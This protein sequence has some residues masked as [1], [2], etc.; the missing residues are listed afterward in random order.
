MI[1]S[2]CP[3]EVTHARS[4]ICKTWGAQS[5]TFALRTMQQ[6]MVLCRE[7][8][9]ETLTSFQIPL[10]YLKLRAAEWI[11]NLKSVK[12]RCEKLLK[13][14]IEQD[15]KRARDMQEAQ[16]VVERDAASKIK[17]SKAT[18]DSAASPPTAS[19]V[20]SA[21][22]KLTSLR[23][24]M[25]RKQSTEER[26]K[27]VIEHMQSHNRIV[28]QYSAA[29]DLLT[30]LFQQIPPNAYKNK[31]ISLTFKKSTDKKKSAL[32]MMPTNLHLCWWR[33]WVPEELPIHDDDFEM[34]SNMLTSNG[35]RPG[36]PGM[37]SGR[38]SS[39]T[40]LLSK[41]DFKRQSMMVPS[42]L[43]PPRSP[44]PA[45]EGESKVGGG[46]EGGEGEEEGGEGGGGGE[47]SDEEEEEEQQ[48]GDTGASMDFQKSFYADGKGEN[49]TIYDC[50]TFGAPAAHVLG[51]KKGGLRALLNKRTKLLAGDDEENED[52]LMAEKRVQWFY[53]DE[54]K[55]EQGPMETKDM[56]HWYAKA[57]LNGDLPTR[58]ST[59]GPNEWIPLSTRFPNFD[60]AFPDDYGMEALESIRAA[61]FIAAGQD[62]S[63]RGKDELRQD[64][65]SLTLKIEQRRDLIVCQSL[66]ALVLSFGAR[67]EVLG[68]RSSKFL[69]QL[70]H[71]G[72]LFQVES[73]V[74][75]HGDEQGML[76]DFI[77]AM[78][79]L[80][81][82]AFRLQQ[83]GG[84]KDAVKQDLW[85][86][87]ENLT[88]IRGRMAAT[89]ESSDKY[90]KLAEAS[91]IL[92]GQ[93]RE[94]MQVA[95]ESWYYC[96]DNMEVR[97]PFPASHMQSWYPDYLDDNIKI[98][99]EGEGTELWM[100]IGERFAHC[101]PFPEPSI[102]AVRVGQGL[103]EISME[104][105]EDEKC[106]VTIKVPDHLWAKLPETLKAGQLI[107][108]FPVLIQQGI[109]EFQTIANLTGSR[110]KL[111]NV[112]NSN[113]VK[114]Y[115][116]YMEKVEAKAHEIGLD[117]EEIKIAQRLFHDLET[118]V[119]KENPRRKNVEIIQ[120]AQ[121]ATRAL[122]GGRG[123]CCKSAKDRTSMS[124]TLEEAQ[125]LYHNE[126]ET[127]IEEVD[128]AAARLSVEDRTILANANILREYGV[129][130]LL[131]FFLSSF[132]FFPSSD[133]CLVFV[134]AP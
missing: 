133:S 1:L 81:N 128:R 88:Q 60:E 2:K 129:S 83:L 107:N 32:R 28:S 53:L 121:R 117:S 124:H 12:E 84:V 115:K 111:Q 63:N 89:T 13:I 120:C 47:E 31:C 30:P 55:T 15:E 87:R 20:A 4:T 9:H 27:W 105:G 59:D 125:L 119:S 22:K 96:D 35:S 3:Y 62:K 14:F 68:N 114:V 5:Q 40:P 71:V 97:G 78:K 48:K 66:S 73:L 56:R 132:T 42:M 52:L 54:E 134:V 10:L 127:R 103:T 113:A 85:K 36:T 7:E 16:E 98:L 18:D 118:V 122:R 6:K 61:E 93:I 44:P 58:L 82:V 109:N 19:E 99:K 39:S 79:E 65:E 34:L 74:S 126:A 110:S 86:K 26:S 76:D 38:H 131:F 57:L 8:V 72:Y 21:K 102:A 77:E 75:T 37:A 25:A 101:Q 64:A 92:E 112:V 100:T 41:S 91:D 94:S 123:I 17:G 29:I 95:E 11:K 45:D 49:D 67:L 130:F 50:V 80:N 24:E 106:I 33:V 46:G 70:A 69:H 104:R 43:P 116:D 51:F 108:V 23:K 90:K